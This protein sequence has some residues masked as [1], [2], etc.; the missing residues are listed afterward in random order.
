M[1]QRKS[2]SQAAGARSSAACCAR[3]EWYLLLPEG[4]LQGIEAEQAPCDPGA[5][6]DRP[7]ESCGHVAILSTD[8]DA[9]ALGPPRDRCDPGVDVSESLL[10]RMKLGHRQATPELRRTTKSDRPAGSNTPYT[11][12]FYPKL[13]PNAVL[14]ASPITSSG[15][16]ESLDRRRRGERAA[17]N[18][19]NQVLCQA[20]ALVSTQRLARSRHIRVDT[21]L[22][23]PQLN[24][25]HRP[26][27][28]SASMASRATRLRLR[29]L[30]QACSDLLSL[31]VAGFGSLSDLTCTG[32]FTRRDA[33]GSM[34]AG[35]TQRHP[36]A[37]TA[38][39]YPDRTVSGCLR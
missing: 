37:R 20:V 27:A 6:V 11:A 16:A 32:E 28:R 36:F 18:A 2:R 4:F 33:H 19:P 31:R 15:A 10:L 30:F 12:V 13:E 3:E 25:R 8:V 9:R 17:G 29:R 35:L 26:V 23:I 7:I 5:V 38:N 22:D 24:R 14:S 1:S 39:A 21:Y 34:V